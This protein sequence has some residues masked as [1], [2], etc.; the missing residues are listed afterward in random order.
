MKNNNYSNLV[1]R[2]T[3][4]GNFKISNSRKKT[5]KIEVEEMVSVF[6]EALSNSDIIM[7]RKIIN[8]LIS[9]NPYIR[10][11]KPYEKIYKKYKE[12]FIK[13][14]TI[15]AEKKVFN[16]HQNQSMSRGKGNKRCPIVV[17]GAISNSISEVSTKDRKS[18]SRMSKR[19]ETQKL[20]RDTYRSLS[21]NKNV[22]PEMLF[23]TTGI[24]IDKIRFNWSSITTKSNHHREIKKTEMIKKIKIK[25]KTTISKEIDELIKQFTLEELDLMIKLRKDGKTIDEITV[26]LE[27]L[28]NL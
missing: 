28:W 21:I 10:N 22:T 26:E 24:D 20:L 19:L 13:K 23:E 14:A 16:L 5:I 2:Y 3:T 6:K 15:E 12:K 18:E 1:K 27:K 25:P 4:L 7:C 9:K 17:P 11:E 8:D